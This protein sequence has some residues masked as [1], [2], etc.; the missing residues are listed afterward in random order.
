MKDL[1]VRSAT[2]SDLDLLVELWL[3]MQKHME[4]SN[5]KIWRITEEGKNSLKERI[6]QMIADKD[7]KV[8]V[9]ERGGDLLGF[10]YGQVS[11]RSEYSPQSVGHIS[12]IYVR[13]EFRRRGI[14]SRLLEELCQFFSSENVEDV[15]IRYVLGNEEAENFWSA[16]RFEPII[17]T[18]D[19]S[20]D[21]LK[22][23]LNERASRF[24]QGE[25]G[26][27]SSC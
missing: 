15:T 11:Q 17:V 12:T 23:R 9:V 27:L 19:L 10:V 22:Q 3:L 24:E 14:G 21:D 6:E 26:S 13:K 2:T 25:N 5:P 20:L 18:A 7:R 8:F 4:T 16:L 1:I